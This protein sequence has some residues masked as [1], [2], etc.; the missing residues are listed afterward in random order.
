[1]RREWK[2]TLATNSDDKYRE[3]CWNLAQALVEIV[4][5]ADVEWESVKN[6]HGVLTITVYSENDP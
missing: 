3:E 4:P 6:D 5:G 2:F 1:M